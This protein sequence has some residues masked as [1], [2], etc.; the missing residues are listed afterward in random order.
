MEQTNEYRIE[1][2]PTRYGQRIQ[3]PDRDFGEASVF[4]WALVAFG[5]VGVLFM[6]GWI[7]FP[8]ITGMGMVF[9]GQWF[10]FLFVAFGMLGMSGLFMSLK[11]LAGGIAIVRNRVGCEI[12]ITNDKLISR[13]TFGWFS[14]R[15]KVDRKKI[16]SLFLRPLLSDSFE[17]DG[18]QTNP[19]IDWLV[20]KLPADWYAISTEQR[21]GSLF[22]PGYP[23]EI[24][25]PL[26][27]LI[28]DELDRNRV[29][30]VSIVDSIPT[31]QVTPDTQ[32]IQQPVSIV[33]Q[34]AEDVEAAPIELPANSSLAISD[35]DGATVYRVPAK[36]VWK[37]SHGLM[38]LGVFWNGFLAFVTLAMLT[39]N[40]EVVADLWVLILVFA[41]FW[42]VGIG[43][44]VGAFYLGSQSALVG[45]REGL[46]FIE[47]KTIFGTKWTEFDPGGIASL[48]TGPSNMEV[49]DRPVM[50]LKIQP[51]GEPEIGMFSQLSADEIHWLAQRLSDQL[52]LQPQSSNSWR[53]HVDP[54]NPLAAPETSRVTVARESNQTLITVPKKNIEGHWSLIMI[55]S[56]FAFG[57]IPAAI[58]GILFLEA[59]LIVIPFAAIGTLMGTVMLVIDRMYSTRWFRLNV[60]GSQVTIERHG[61]LSNKAVT[62]AKEDVRAIT[63]EDSGTKVNGRT[64]MHLAIKSRNASETSTLM[65]GRDER[66]IAYVAAL[67]DDQLGLEA[68]G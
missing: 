36:G 28:K 20:R 27:G 8:A 37:G 1:A 17:D 15:T 3:L 53:R 6:L 41:L 59:S 35:Q 58:A 60:K 4:G 30:L 51:V 10:G 47:R 44:V 13:E 12:Q 39:G 14:H 55:G 46:L 66:E 45:V 25:T 18:G 9:Q 26:T 65:S 64:H 5:A 67:I 32:T 11:L 31:S 54:K 43:I 33:R 52:D 23:T 42:A 24:L 61:F 29:G 38:I 2:E 63:L 62:I 16:D 56:L 50:E 48:H 22:A 7:G 19:P 21:K 57:S 68:T 49:N 34:S 40:G